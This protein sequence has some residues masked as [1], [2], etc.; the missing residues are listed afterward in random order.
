MQPQPRCACV[1]SQQP[2]PAFPHDRLSASPSR[3]RRAWREALDAVRHGQAIFGR[4]DLPRPLGAAEA[5]ASRPSAA[6]Y[7][8]CLACRTARPL[9][10]VPF[11]CTPATCRACKSC[12][13]PQAGNE[14]LLRTCIPSPPLRLLLAARP[15]P[16]LRGQSHSFPFFLPTPPRRLCGWRHPPCPPHFALG[17]SRTGQPGPFFRSR[18]SHAPRFCFRFA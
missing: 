2:L 8:A 7:S 9:S 13:G 1:L 4:S 5:G 12:G 16:S 18:P 11:I 10:A 3:A 17:G 15:R 14:T 6:L